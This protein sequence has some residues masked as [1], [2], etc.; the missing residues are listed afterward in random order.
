MRRLPPKSKDCCIVKRCLRSLDLSPV[1]SADPRQHRCYDQAADPDWINAVCGHVLRRSRCFTGASCELPNLD[2][3]PF[4]M[5]TC[6]HHRTHNRYKL[7]MPGRATVH[8]PGGRASV[9]S[10]T[11][12]IIDGLVCETNAS[13]PLDWVP[14]FV[15]PASRVPLRP[16]SCFTVRG[17]L[18]ARSCSALAAK[19]E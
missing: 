4:K 13:K 5:I 1:L 9:C 2:H 18:L 8:Y 7:D 6:P 16:A 19:R 12:T 10:P 17:I 14:R 11:K 3:F 15:P